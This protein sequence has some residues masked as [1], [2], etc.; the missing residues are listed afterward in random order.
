MAIVAGDLDFFLSSN[1]GSTGGAIS[2]TELNG[3]LHQ[4]FDIVS[5]AEASSGDTEYRC[6]YLKNSAAQQALNAVV[7]QSAD[8]NADCVT[9]IGL[10]TS[11]IGGTE[12]TIA[13]ED[14]APAGVTFSAAG[15]EGA[16]LSIGTIPAGSHKAVWIK[17]TV[18]AAA[19]A[20][21]NVTTT[22]EFK[23]DTEA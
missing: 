17:R 6:V 20:A 1:S 3:S 2:A 4:V 23:V 16:A 15:S 19:S 5:S 18:S 12:Q 10:G 14:T 8:G 21:S 7:W 11:A 9:E 13:D 22:L